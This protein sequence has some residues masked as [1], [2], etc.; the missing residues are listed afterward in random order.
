MLEPPGAPA[1]APRV[2]CPRRRSQL[3][4]SKNPDPEAI[5]LMAR[6][7]EYVP[8]V[9]TEPRDREGERTTAGW[10]DGGVLDGARSRADVHGGKGRRGGDGGD[11]QL[12]LTPIEALAHPF[13]DE[14]RDP[15]TRLSA[16]QPLPALFNFTEQELS[17]RSDL[18]RVLIPAHAEAELRQRFKLEQYLA[19]NAPAVRAYMANPPPS[20]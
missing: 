10:R 4:R 1:R 2:A 11:V 6:L 16:V 17:Q 13:F 12:R 19:P 3:F 5:D 20:G 7:L 15:A 8:H 9:R 14:L 18:N